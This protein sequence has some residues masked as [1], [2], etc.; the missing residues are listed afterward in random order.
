[1]AHRVMRWPISVEQ[2][3]LK[4][5]HSHLNPLII[6]FIV[7]RRT[8]GKAYWIPGTAT[9]AF[10]FAIPLGASLRSSPHEASD[11]TPA[12]RKVSYPLATDIKDVLM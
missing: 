5:K 2:A 6:R 8:F 11:V 1:M 10:H 9:I 4:K 7:C 3:P 12:L